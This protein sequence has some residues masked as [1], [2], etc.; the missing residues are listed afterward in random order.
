M[1]SGWIPE[2]VDVDRPTAARIY[3]YL[4]GGF[5]NFAADREMA[6]ATIAA[7]PDAAVQAQ[8]NRA[9]LHRAVRLLVNEGIRQFRNLGS[10]IPTLGNVHEIA[11]GVAPESRVVYVDIDPVA[12]EHSRHIL[13]DNDRATAIHADL[14]QPERVLAAAETREVLDFG[15]PIAVLAVAVLHAV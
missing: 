11:H 10:G 8:A 13:A 7:I 1:E 5:H 6:R 3:D 4:L 14:R 2:G 15:Q 9:F 12:V